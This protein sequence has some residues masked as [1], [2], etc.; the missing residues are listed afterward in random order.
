MKIFTD[1][2]LDECTDRL[3][4]QKKFPSLHNFFMGE[5]K[6]TQDLTVEEVG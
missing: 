3:F 5:S 6:L 4:F 2:Y 1:E